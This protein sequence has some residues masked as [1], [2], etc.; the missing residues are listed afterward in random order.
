[1]EIKDVAAV[2]LTK[3]AEI[4]KEYI[5]VISW[6][7]AIAGILLIIL[8]L[9]I[10]ILY[11][12]I[13]S[14]PH[15]Q[16]RKPTPSVKPKQEE[17][18][19]E[20]EV[21][22]EDL[23]IIPGRL[24]EILA[25]NGL[26]KVGP[27]TKIFLQVLD[28]LK[29]S[30]YDIRWRYKI[31]CFM[32][33][34]P[35]KSGKSF[36]V[37]S[38]NL[39]MLTDESTGAMWKLFKQG[40]VFECPK[41]DMSEK[42][43]WSFLS[44]LFLFIR[45]RRP[46]DGVIVT[47]PA[48]LLISDSANVTKV[49]KGTFE[50]I[51]QFQRDINFR[52]PIYLIVTKSDLITGFSDFAHLLHH[53]MKQQ[54][55]GWSC[56]YTLKTQFSPKWIDEIFHTILSG[57]NKANLA[58]AHSKVTSAVLNNALLFPIYF[59]R[60]KPVLSEYI[61]TMFRTHSPEDGLI[62]RG[63]YFVGE[64]KN[65]E[66]PTHELLEPNALAPKN[67]LDFDTHISLSVNN[68]LYFLQD[69]FSEKIFNEGNI[70]CPL[71]TNTPDMRKNEFRRQVIYVSATAAFVLGWMYGNFNIKTTVAQYFDDLNEARNAMENIFKLEHSLSGV[72]DKFQIDKYTG[73]LLHHLPKVK[74]FDFFS[75]FVPQSWFSNIRKNVKETIN[76]AFDS[77]I[78]RAIYIDL[79]L[80][81]HRLLENTGDV[82]K[83]RIPKTDLFDINSFES[84][85]KLRNFSSQIKQMRKMGQQYNEMRTQANGKELI[86]ITKELLK[87]QFDTAPELK[88]HVPNKMLTIPK[89]D[90]N[91]FNAN[92]EKSLKMVFDEFLHDVLDVTI[93]KILQSVMADVDLLLKASRN[94]S[95]DYSTQN[96][97]KLYNKC[98]LVK[99][100]LKNKNFAWI[101][102]DHFIPNVEYANIMNELRTS[103]FIRG[104]CISRLLARGEKEFLQFKEKLR[105]CKTEMTGN[106]LQYSMQNV[107]DDFETFI[108]EL[109]FLLDAPFICATPYGKLNTTISNEK[110][111]IWS[112]KRLND[113]SQLI[114]KYYEFDA[115]APV[116][117]RSQFFE[118]YK[119]VTR[120]CFY[121]VIQA[122]L[123]SAEI[124]QDVPLGSSGALLEEA[125]KKQ[126]TN[127]RAVTTFLPKIIK[128]IDE[129]QN[130]D[131]LPDCGAIPMIIT[132][133]LDLLRRI[134]SLF[135]AEKPYSAKSAVFDGWNGDYAPRYLDIDNQNDLRRYLA[136]QFEHIKFLAKELAEPVVDL[137]SIP[138]VRQ[139]IQNPVLLDKWKD[140]I[141]SVNDYL[142]KKPGNS[143]AALEEFLSQT[144]RKVS[145]DNFDEQGDIRNFSKDGGDYFIQTRSTVAKSLLSR[146]D[147]VKYDR[148]SKS[149]MKIREFF[150]ANLSKKV[151]FGRSH[152][153]ASL[154]DIETFIQLY[155]K[156]YKGMYE[157]LLKHKEAK[158]VNTQAIEFLKDLEQLM[159][160]L[161]IWMRHIKGTDENS[162]V[163]LFNVRVRPD[164]RMEVYTSAV[165]ERNFKIN[166]VL[167]R[168][169]QSGA[170]FNN[171][172]ISV[173]FK[174]VEASDEKPRTF[175]SSAFSA[176]GSFAK[177]KFSGKWALFQLLEKHK[178]NM[179][180]DNPNG[181]LVK[182]E[183]PLKNKSGEATSASSIM[184]LKVTPM[185]KEE[186]KLTPITWPVFPAFAPDLHIITPV[187]E[188]ERASTEDELDA[189]ASY[190]GDI[191][192]E[193]TKIDDEAN[194]IKS[195]E[196]KER[197]SSTE[198]KKSDSD[199]DEE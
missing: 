66:I 88:N 6:G 141:T 167:I 4:P 175:S 117:I 67:A 151:P 132:Q 36:L 146:A 95:V 75:V 119:N 27:T 8:S 91:L 125:Y 143:I 46:L 71:H 176:D 170:Y 189:I 100:L 198:E 155:D 178:I 116:E 29:R 10:G 90:M 112:Q 185:L 2:A 162:A 114:D 16:L 25:L 159:P 163:L 63:V 17:V 40:I 49:A 144:L 86:N 80:D 139:H 52:L 188:D 1:M 134:D 140:I 137:L 179:E 135:N 11:I 7:F 107:S 110:M 23:P 50:N 35:G 3:I 19:Q 22:Y 194:D 87:G 183:V 158:S 111:L 45:P 182:F 33:I 96:L 61:N 76:L 127:V 28:V 199:G 56:P 30:T 124:L 122:T 14:R 44:E 69:L 165:I 13:M 164:P 83:K 192:E 150:N 51:F 99:D 181:V 180:T 98:M 58:F 77:I 94:A 130:D 5:S 84:F 48:D 115:N 129:I 166:D 42:K 148:A 93:N 131:H 81:T 121:P 37:N 147:E 65:V 70:A 173:E 171:D 12:N 31:P 26:L 169:D 24:G 20:V 72:N 104:E 133:Y 38:L 128:I 62:F 105:E 21:H 82:A 41:S 195:R 78:T 34:G 191:K 196:N 118:D 85:K 174:W 43:F 60:I 97:A 106:L 79:N 142:E 73:E 57:I 89:F 123:G 54:I 197:E 157:T 64:Q 138:V 172:K 168:D 149:Y 126:A 109:K 74:W 113:L 120:K 145:I 101:K 186:D 152:S 9:V 160:F 59:N 53:D 18:L 153:D 47:L 39:E 92:A 156:G 177:F 136:A 108:K 190:E 161:K 154:R 102:Q 184:V 68:R 193:D 55:F 32:L 15:P 187:E 103:G